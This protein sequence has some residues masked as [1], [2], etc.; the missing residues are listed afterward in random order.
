METT[1]EMSEEKSRKDVRRYLIPICS[2][3]GIILAMLILD[4][5]VDG[6]GA[7]IQFQRLGL[8]YLKLIISKPFIMQLEEFFRYTV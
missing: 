6:D 8:W 2:V 1:D 7:L 4:V 3:F 5:F